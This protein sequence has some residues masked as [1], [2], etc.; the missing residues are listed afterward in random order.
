M[1]CRGNGVGEDTEEEAWDDFG[2]LRPD[3]LEHLLIWGTI[4]IEA[5]FLRTL[6]VSFR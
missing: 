2:S 4:E 3:C 6:D 1:T 5:V